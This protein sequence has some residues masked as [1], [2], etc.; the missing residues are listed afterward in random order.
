MINF[1]FDDKEATKLSD[2][3]RQYLIDHNAELIDERLNE[4]GQHFH[5]EFNSPNGPNFL[6]V[7]QEQS[8]YAE[9]TKADDKYPIYGVQDSYKENPFNLNKDY[10]KT[11]NELLQEGQ[12]FLDIGPDSTF[13]EM[14][15]RGPRQKETTEADSPQKERQGIDLSTTRIAES[16]E[17]EFTSYKRDPV[18]IYS[19]ERKPL[20]FAKT[21]KGNYESKWLSHKSEADIREEYRNQGVRMFEGQNY[22]EAAGLRQSNWNKIGRGL[23]T[24]A[25]SFMQVG[26]STISSIII[27]IPS[28]IATGEFRQV[29]ANPVNAAIDEYTKWY[30][31]QY[32]HHSTEAEREEVL[33]PNF[34]TQQLPQG[35]GFLVGAAVTGGIA[36][37]LKL[38]AGAY[39]LV[40]GAKNVVRANAAA[41]R[42]R[43]LTFMQSKRAL[44]IIGKTATKS[45]AANFMGAGIISAVGEASIEANSIY[46]QSIQHMEEMK[47]QGDPRFK[48]MNLKEIQTAAASYANVAW[49]ANTIIVGGSNMLMFKNLFKSGYTN[50][51]SR[52]LKGLVTREGAKVAMKKWA[53][54]PLY[55]KAKSA[56]LRLKI[57]LTETGEEWS[58]YAL[59]KGGEDYFKYNYNPGLE[60]MASLLE[61]AIGM[62]QSVGRGIAQTPTE[63]EGQQSMLLGFM[64]GAL[65]SS[66][67]AIQGTSER[68]QWEAQFESTKSTIEYVNAW[69]EGSDLH[70]HITALARMEKAEIEQVRAIEDQDILV[71]KSQE[72]SKIFHTLDLYSELGQLEAFE[73]LLED[74]SKMDNDTFGKTFELAGYENQD[75]ESKESQEAR[76]LVPISKADVSNQIENIRRRVNFFKTSASKVNAAVD[77]VI[78]KIVANYKGDKADLNAKIPY[79]KSLLKYYSWMS[80]DFDQREAE[81]KGELSKMSNGA[82]NTDSVFHALLKDA[83]ID[84][85]EDSISE[86]VFLEGLTK[87]E[88]KEYQNPKDLFSAKE[89]EDKYNYTPGVY[90][91]TFWGRA[92]KKYE[93]QVAEWDKQDMAPSPI[94][95]A[96]AAQKFRDALLLNIQKKQFNNL[97]NGILDDPG[98]VIDQV[99][100]A[101]ENPAVKAAETEQAIINDE[102]KSE[103]ELKQEQANQQANEEDIPP[104]PD[105]P[106]PTLTDAAQDLADKNGLTDF[107][108][109]EG[110]GKEGKITKRDIQKHLKRIQN[111]ST[112]PR[113][114]QD[115][116]EQLVNQKN[117][118]EF[119]VD[120]KDGKTKYRNKKTGKFYERVTNV[121]DSKEVVQNEILK[122]ASAIGT[123]V[124]ELVRDFFSDSLK[125]ISEYARDVVSIQNGEQI[126]AEF[127]D[128]LQQ[129]KD[130][131]D[132]EGITVLANDI[133]LFND[134]LG[135][136]L[137]TILQVTFVSMI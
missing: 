26:T 131:F 110:T 3:G 126:I 124:D 10:D 136:Y 128:Q 103:E 66:R 70:K 86:E 51:T 99:E 45:Q 97:V 48:D 35:I 122:S 44:D 76:D 93:E 72:A 46:W 30:G 19:T 98:T 27:G 81:L 68:Q 96:Q 58:Q 15:G 116:V 108:M 47:H 49:L 80:Q 11:Y 6:G 12:D 133:V 7:D 18:E 73:E 84:L 33:S 117:D 82:I 109:V 29:F 32:P 39:K 120:P 74:V 59:E 40:A 106:P 102:A 63:V 36:A 8:V 14:F 91:K 17:D 5:L 43:G 28:A 61:G 24:M 135:I 55:K 65:G 90:S 77:G 64:L 25:T 92:V 31:E 134:E 50:L 87:E 60:G 101:E 129:I 42:A 57:P 16:V 125:P 41:F 85:K 132:S 95:K 130:H 1:F 113:K 78:D 115:I 94:D 38:G 13:M 52:Y 105:G 4:G 54:K 123:K 2:N 75:Q 62:T 23:G 107:S 21:P 83:G 67:A 104:P 121:I 89:I 34:W 111:V 112:A 100:L 53:A 37:E 137:L 79:L 119:A 56:A 9:G 71:S 114:I 127:I 69:A 20:T 88:L 22:E 118:L